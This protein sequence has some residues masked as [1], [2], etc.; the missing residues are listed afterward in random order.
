[1]DEH[2]EN[3]L[4]VLTYTL[5]VIV[6]FSVYDKAALFV[7]SPTQQERAT[8]SV[9]NAVEAFLG[10][11]ARGASESVPTTP[12]TQAADSIVETFL[13]TPSYVT[14]V[15]RSVSA[16]AAQPLLQCLPATIT[17]GEPALIAWFCNE[18]TYEASFET[19]GVAYGLQRVSPQKT[20]RYTLTCGAA[21]SSIPYACTVTVIEP[22]A[23]L[24]APNAVA[25]GASANVYW[26]SVGTTSCTL[27]SDTNSTFT[28]SGVEGD[29]QTHAIYQPTTFTLVCETQSGGVLEKSVT[30]RAN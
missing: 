26:S 10:L 9:L 8:A 25:S 12:T 21:A 5:I 22:T 15:A 13:N 7:Q 14:P 30:V 11:G 17:R 20:T 18:E 29:V 19:G 16:Y 1:M 2:I 4:Q 6:A 23:A 27:S 3:V 24:R 28:R